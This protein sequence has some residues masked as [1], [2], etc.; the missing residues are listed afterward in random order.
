MNDKKTAT[1]YLK[2]LAWNWVSNYC[3]QGVLDTVQATDILSFN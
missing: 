1:V 2:M 3:A